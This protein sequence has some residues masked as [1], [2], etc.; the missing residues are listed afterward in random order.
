M[1]LWSHS[2]VRHQIA[3]PVYPELISS[4]PIY[5]YHSITRP[6]VIDIFNTITYLPLPCFTS[7]IASPTTSFPGVQV[8]SSPHVRP[9]ESSI[10]D[11]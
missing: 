11:G 3:L 1:L 4:G 7:R 2:N 10:D 6:S 9:A 8:E 5:P